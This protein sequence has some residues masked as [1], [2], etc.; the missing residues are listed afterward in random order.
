MRCSS[1]DR[2]SNVASLSTHDSHIARPVKLLISYQKSI[3]SLEYGRQH[4]NASVLKVEASICCVWEQLSEGNRGEQRGKEWRGVLWYSC[5]LH[6]NWKQACS[7]NHSNLFSFAE[8]HSLIPSHTVKSH[9]HTHTHTHTESLTHSMKYRLAR[10]LCLLKEKFTV[11]FF[12]FNNHCHVV[13]KQISKSVHFCHTSYP[14]TAMHRYM[15][16]TSL[17]HATMQCE[18]TVSESE[19]G[20]AS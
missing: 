12:I 8:P 6:I 9:S 2:K 1:W 5:C 16:P 20:A 13:S 17:R 7:H 3:L 15:Q 10:L 14:A 18:A 4:T 11:S 19:P